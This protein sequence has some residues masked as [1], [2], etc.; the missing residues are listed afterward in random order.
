[1]DF[2]EVG[3]ALLREHG[4][5]LE[6]AVEVLIELLAEESAADSHL[7]ISAVHDDAVE[8]ASRLPEEFNFLHRVILHKLLFGVVKA[9]QVA[10][11]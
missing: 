7:G 5:R 1:L 3:V 9:H 10:E 4:P 8:L 2:V 6:Q 11:L